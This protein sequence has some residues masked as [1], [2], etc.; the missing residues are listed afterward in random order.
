M[1]PYPKQQD[2]QL[3]AFADPVMPSLL[4]SGKQG[5]SGLEPR[6]ERHPLWSDLPCFVATGQQMLC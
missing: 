4:G 2:S 3:Q 6:R 5:E 1:L